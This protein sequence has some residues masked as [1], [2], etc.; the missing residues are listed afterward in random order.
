MTDDLVELVL[1]QAGLL[2]GRGHGVAFAHVRLTERGHRLLDLL[3]TKADLGREV[4]DRRR[5]GH[6]AENAVEN[7]HR[8]T[9]IQRLA[10]VQ[11][12]TVGTV[13]S[14]SHALATTGKPCHSPAL[15]RGGGRG[16]V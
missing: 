7:A 4:L 1:R 15:N 16:Q 9:S 11:Y 2:G 8:G 12:T 13:S 6:L 5:I 14:L 3:R 10:R